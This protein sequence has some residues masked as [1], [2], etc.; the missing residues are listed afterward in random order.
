MAA[1]IRERRNADLEVRE[2]EGGGGNHDSF[3]QIIEKL[4]ENHSRYRELNCTNFYK[5]CM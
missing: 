5:V 1:A 3:D 2:N 4:H